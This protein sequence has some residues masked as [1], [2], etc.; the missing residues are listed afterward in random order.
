MAGLPAGGHAIDFLQ[1]VGGECQAKGARATGA[2]GGIERNS[3]L[4]L[5]HV[6]MPADQAEGAGGEGPVQSLAICAANGVISVVD[7]ETAKT[8]FVGPEGETRKA[9]CPIPPNQPMIMEAPHSFGPK[10]KQQLFTRCLQYLAI[11]RSPCTSGRSRL[12][13]GAQY[14]RLLRR[15]ASK[16]G[17]SGKRSRLHPLVVGSLQGPLPLHPGGYLEQELVKPGCGP[18]VSGGHS[19]H[20]AAHGPVIHSDGDASANTRLSG[21]PQPAWSCRHRA[22]PAGTPGGMQWHCGRW[23]P[24]ST[25][26]AP[27]DVGGEV[28]ARQWNMTAWEPLGSGPASG[29]DCT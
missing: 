24:G 16:H 4:T 8:V 18:E 23:A 12:L 22:Q 9:N 27:W 11:N 19:R 20:L 13:T 28:P 2:R 14:C 7:L 6:T 1:F 10:R 26:G 21:G 15:I 29:H 17:W 25:R 5:P 3:S